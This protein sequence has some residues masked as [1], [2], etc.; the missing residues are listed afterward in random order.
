MLIGGDHSADSR[1]IPVAIEGEREII[2]RALMRLTIKKGSF[3][4]DL[5]LGSELYRLA[6]VRGGDLARIALGY[7]QEALLPMPEVSVTGVRVEQISDDALRLYVALLISG[8]SYQL[9]VNIA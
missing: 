2:Q 4:L 5:E 1:G 8:Q 6:S 3:P 9:E 7:A